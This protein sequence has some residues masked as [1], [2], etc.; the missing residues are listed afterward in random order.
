MS[1][2]ISL[3]GLSEFLTK[4]RALFYTKPNSGI[5]A[6]DLASSVQTSLGKADSAYQKSNSGIPKTDLASGVQSSL[7]LADSSVQA[8]PVGSVTP[9][10]DPYDY[11]TREELSQL[12]QEVGKIEDVIPGSAVSYT[13]KIVTLENLASLPTVSG[14]NNF[15]FAGKNLFDVSTRVTG[16]IKNDSGTEVNDGTSNYFS[17][18]IPVYGGVKITSNITIQRIYLYTPDKQWIGRYGNNLTTFDVPATHNNQTVG[19]MQI[20]MAK[21]LISDTMMVNYGET[22]ETFEAYKS[23][24]GTE[25]YSDYMIVYDNLLADIVVSVGAFANLQE[26]LISGENIKT[27]NGENILGPGNLDI[28]FNVGMEEIELSGN[29]I[30]LESTLSS[31]EL[32]A[33][34]NV[35]GRNL[36]DGSSQVF[37]KIKNDSGTEVSDGTSSY[38]TTFIPAIG[39]TIL[40]ANVNLQRLYYYD[41]NKN[42]I[43]RS[44][45]A[46]DSKTREVPATVSNTAVGWVQVQIPHGQLPQEGLM[47]NY[48]G[49]AFAYEAYKS[50]NTPALYPGYSVVFA[51]DLSSI[52]ISG[53]SL[54]MIALPQISIPEVWE[55]S[56]VESGYS[57]P[58]GSQNTIRAN[59]TAPNKY[60]YYD[61]L[62]YYYDAYIG[63]SYADKYKVSKRSVGNDCSNLG[64]EMF[65]YDFCPANYTKVVLL[66]AGMNTNETS[67]IWGVATFIH[68]LMNPAEPTMQWLHD[69]VR[70]VVLPIICPSSFDQT[71]LKYENYNGVRV[72]K[73][74]NYKDSWNYIHNNYTG[75]KEGT[76][77]DS[78]AETVNLKKWINKYSGIA[79]FYIDCHSDDDS[80]GDNYNTI[81]TQV[82]CSDSAI[83][84]KID[85]TFSALVTFYTNKGYISEGIT[86]KTQSWVEG[87]T[88]YPKT[89][90]AKNFCQIPSIMIE[91]YICSTMYG[92]DGQTNNDTYG[93]KNYCA[94][95]RMYVMAALVQSATVVP[96]GM[97]PMN[98]YRVNYK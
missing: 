94:M 51:N 20:Q 98:G 38:Y 8:N 84:A 19:W 7:D 92:S 66:S 86:A 10:V 54:S 57:S 4:C 16:K 68:E 3:T 60:L 63:G 87:G 70:F 9:A 1:K 32:P 28:D 88:I 2:F 46:T 27:I 82:I 89:V 67:G 43:G 11:A 80:R 95:L 62:A 47:V 35:T 79:D 59:W 65:E 24:A 90:Y 14:S 6:S 42:W 53:K 13:G 72:N 44:S 76:Y 39:G 41:V 74:F 78:E 29:I 56:W 25:Y 26:E 83:K 50:N 58:I 34:A 71:P 97:I 12:G 49:A 73:N 93:I 18:Y 5:P 52:T 55:P 15:T 23:N 85:A 17:G 22:S 75:Q 40:S 96:T 48:G 91:Q 33:A 31:A 81:L 30:V 64:Y 77:P 45:A 61:F 21:S 36:V 37:K 69:N